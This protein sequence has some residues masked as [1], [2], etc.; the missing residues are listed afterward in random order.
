M[1]EHARSLVEVAPGETVRVRQVIFDSLRAYCGELG[2]REGERVTRLEDSPSNVLL[3][4]AGGRVVRC[5]SE[6]A[7]FVEV[8]RDRGKERS[9]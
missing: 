1:Q 8:A 3:R 5:P 4:G 7:R 2:L 9:R 6:Y